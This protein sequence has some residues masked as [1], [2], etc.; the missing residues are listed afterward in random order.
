[1]NGP[2][3]DRNLE[4]CAQDSEVRALHGGSEPIY[5]NCLPSP[6]NLSHQPQ[7]VRSVESGSGSTPETPF[8]VR[9][10]LACRYHVILFNVNPFF[11]ADFDS[12]VDGHLDTDPPFGG[13]L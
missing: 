2:L 12:E 11:N 7:I 5:D 8:R 3:L 9:L 10:A 6:P 13:H 1:M 4:S